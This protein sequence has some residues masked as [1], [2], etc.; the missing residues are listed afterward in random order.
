MV[1]EMTKIGCIAALLSVSASANANFV[2]NGSFENDQL[3]GTRWQV[4]NSIDG[5]STESGPGIEIQR[6]TI[7]K[8]QQGNQYVELDS[9]NA[10]D[11]NSLMA[12]EITGLTTGW[13][14]D[15]SF[16]YHA[17][18][19]K[20][21]NDNGINVYWGD[22]LPFDELTDEIASIEDYVRST[23]N[24]WIRFDYNVLATAET[25]YL[26]FGAD[27]LDNSLGGFIDNISLVPEPASG[28]LF[29]LGLVGLGLARRR[30]K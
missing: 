15:L 19:N 23:S 20:G 6:N 12:Q 22:S 1:K 28:A 21:N 16:Y 3:T 30:N 10:T 24:A 25:M 27:G 18:T 7:V 2:T 29:G 9:H 4:F 5:W 17:R 11:T 26:G 8:A 13:T 14:Y